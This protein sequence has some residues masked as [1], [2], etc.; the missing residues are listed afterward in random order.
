MEEAPL[1]G[2]ALDTSVGS[3]AKSS[4]DGSISR[5]GIGGDRT[6]R[7]VVLK[8][9]NFKNALMEDMSRCLQ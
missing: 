4:V 6:G 9:I 1:V 8:I 2:L 5:S 7:R 3:V